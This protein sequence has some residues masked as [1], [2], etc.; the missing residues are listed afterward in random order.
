MSKNLYINSIR[1]ICLLTIKIFRK[2]L[3]T[4][5]KFYIWIILL[6]N[7][8]FYIN[9]IDFIYLLIIWVL[10]KNSYINNTNYICLLILWIFG[11][12]RHANSEIYCLYSTWIIISAMKDF[13]RFYYI[14]Y[15]LLRYMQLL[16]SC[17]VGFVRL[18]LPQISRIFIFITVGPWSLLL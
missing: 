1:S 18:F 5:N 10:N 12:I 13:C 7:K 6:F 8:I 3:Y 2:I 17:H 16:L 11:K 9:S 4:D 14:E 15:W